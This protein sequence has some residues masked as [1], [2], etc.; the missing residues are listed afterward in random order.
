LFRADARLP[1]NALA[2]ERFFVK[3]PFGRLVNVL[4]HSAS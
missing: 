4:V 3:A 2:D 1:R